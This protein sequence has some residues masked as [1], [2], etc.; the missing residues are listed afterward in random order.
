[1]TPGETVAQRIFSTF[2]EEVTNDTTLFVGQR[3]VRNEYDPDGGETRYAWVVTEYVLSHVPQ[4]DDP[5]IRD[6]VV[7]SFKRTKARDLAKARAEDLA[8]ELKRDW[9][10]QKVKRKRCP[11]HWTARPFWGQQNRQP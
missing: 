2:P 5:G 8:K 6:Q 1:V 4:L 11:K 3:A 7:L 10:S 9:R